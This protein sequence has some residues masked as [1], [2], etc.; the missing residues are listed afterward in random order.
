MTIKVVVDNFPSLRDPVL[1]PDSLTFTKPW[2]WCLAEHHLALHGAAPNAVVDLVNGTSQ[3]GPV[4]PLVPVASPWIYAAVQQGTLVVSSAQV[5]LSRDLGAN[6]LLVSPMG[7]AV[8]MLANDWVKIIWYT[9]NKPTVN[10]LPNG[11][12]A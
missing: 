8:P 6:W 4:V 7:G 5:E 11:P 1:H 10:F 9:S 12:I 3:G 2:Y